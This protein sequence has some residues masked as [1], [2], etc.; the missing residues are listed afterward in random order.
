MKIDMRDAFF[1]KLV[2]HAINDPNI[3]ILTADHGAFALRDFSKLYSKQYINIGISEQNMIGVAAG[4]ALSGKTVFVYGISPFVSLRVLEHLTIDVAAMNLPV[5]VVSVGAGFTYSTDGQT[6]L[7]LQDVG[8]IMTIPGMTILNSSDPQNTSD[9]VDLAISSQKPHYIR[10]EK[11]NLDNFERLNSNY[12][13]DGFSLLVKGIYN[14][15]V[16]STGGISHDINK[17]AKE[18]ERDGSN[19]FWLVDLHQL[20]PLNY[21][22]LAKLVSNF[23][24][25]ILIDESYPTGLESIIS[26]FCAKI[27]WE[28]KIESFCV[29]G[30]SLTFEGA[31]RNDIKLLR[32]LASVNLKLIIDKSIVKNNLSKI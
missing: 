20:K 21:S 30:E 23:S 25:L 14:T 11:E 6:H 29:D 22:S 13:E 4:L 31:N 16:I 19:N 5:N 24:H 18:N 3:I 17:I 1:N 2:S 15:L 28:G 10:I 8:A 9:F 27:K 32:G 12:L 26:R 7:G